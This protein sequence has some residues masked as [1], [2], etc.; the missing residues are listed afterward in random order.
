MKLET[1]AKKA[2]GDNVP[3]WIRTSLQLGAVGVI[4]TVFM[5]WSDN[6]WSLQQEAT[7]SARYFHEAHRTE[8]KDFRKELRD[9]QDRDDAS[10]ARAWETVKE[11]RK[12]IDEL[13]IVIKTRM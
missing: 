10:R 12:S 3:A 5:R 13:T 7:E 11:L 1:V 2:I 8:L 9:Q 4:C 6:V